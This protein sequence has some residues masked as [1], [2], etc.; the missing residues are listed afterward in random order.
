ME[1]KNIV[2]RVPTY[3]GR[4]K[5]TPV[6]GMPDLFIMERADEPR[7]E[8]TPID[9]ATLDSIIQSRL[10]GRFYASTVTK[11]IISSK[12]GLTTSP[13]PLSGWTGE[14]LLRKSGGYVVSADS[15]YNSTAFINEAFSNSGG[16]WT[17]TAGTSHWLMIE[18]PTPITLKKIKLAI[19]KSSSSSAIMTS[20]QASNDGAAWT[21]LTTITGEVGTG[22]DITLPNTTPY[23]FYK[24]SFSLS[25]SARV[26]VSRWQFSLYDITT[27]RNNFV[28]SNG[29]PLVFSGGQRIAFET[30]NNTN[31]LGV[32]ENTINGQRVNIILQPNTR[33][34]LHYA[35]GLFWGKEA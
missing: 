14:T 32:E 24:L 20:V 15:N 16:N 10:T 6:S 18:L 11:E 2:D 4:I 31:A 5:L 35:N 29:V 9:K 3:P 17:S 12:E 7:E 22:T 25:E 19:G 21:D 30:P 27:Y 28:I 13:I 33:Y 26:S 23:K 1:E 8:G 34:L